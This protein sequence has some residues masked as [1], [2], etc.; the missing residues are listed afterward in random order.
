MKAFCKYTKLNINILQV[1]RF[2]LLGLPI[3]PSCVVHFLLCGFKGA[4]HLTVGFQGSDSGFFVFTHEAAVI[5]SISTE[6]SGESTFKTFI[7]HN[8]TSFFRF[9]TEELSMWN[10]RKSAK[11]RWGTG[12][13]SGNGEPLQVRW[14]WKFR[15]NLYASIPKSMG[16]FNQKFRILE[17]V[18]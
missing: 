17:L 3:K 4:K 10:I 8:G 16:F 1:S 11:I 15:N 9:Q 12:F 6:D 13:D 5:D 2:F 18:I 7:C 14:N